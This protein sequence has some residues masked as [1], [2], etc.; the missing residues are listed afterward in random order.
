MKEKIIVYLFIVYLFFFSFLGM[1]IKDKEISLTERR[2]L[3][4]FP[5][6]SVSSDYLKKVEKYLL[7]QFPFRDE[8][9]NIKANYN[10]KILR[11]LDN[12]GIYI[13]KN[14]IFK[15]E[16]K[17]NFSSISNFS[18]HI[19]KVKE[20]L[21]KKNKVYM[22]FIPDKNYY[23]EDSN[24]IKLDYKYIYNELRKLE[25]PM[26]D[27]RDS[28]ELNDYYETDPHLR[29]ERLEK[30]IERLGEKMNF[31]YKKQ[32]YNINTYDKFYGAY[33]KES[34]LKRKP[35]VLN[36]FTNKEIE[37]CM[38]FYLENKNLHS[39]Y[40]IDKLH[41]IDSYSLYLDGASSFITIENLNSNTNRELVVFRDSFA[42]S[43]APLLVSY[44]KKI[45]LIDNRY[46]KSDKYLDLIEFKDQDIL[47]MY[48]T[49]LIN[50]SFSLKN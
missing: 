14:H 37:N 13:Y 22:M 49:L 50:N 46:I 45:T 28:L 33:Y 17:V 41:S 9:R 11:K 12:N 35:E 34:A 20:Q 27:I 2:K 38:V 10:Y 4:T 18:N 7:D 15:R 44:Y 8:F 19:E 5:S 29:Q 26:I 25:I 6:F 21:N 32:I 47:F 48:S 16:S 42:S 3:E 36:Y 23:L 43:L 40:N 31:S 30:V 39:I 24:F 1:I